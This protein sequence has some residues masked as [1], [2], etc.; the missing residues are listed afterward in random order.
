MDSS[1]KTDKYLAEKHLFPL[2]Y[3]TPMKIPQEMTKN[4]ET[5]VCCFFRNVCGFAS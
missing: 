3:N 2:D 4:L 1:V 5:Q